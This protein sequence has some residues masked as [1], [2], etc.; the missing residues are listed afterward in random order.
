MGSLLNEGEIMT[1]R[2]LGCLLLFCT[3]GPL[4]A[5]SHGHGH[6]HVRM[7][8][9][10]LDTACAI[11]TGDTAQSI[12]FGTLAVSDLL[13]NGRSVSVPFTI[14]LVNCVLNGSDVR[15]RDHWKDV[16]I[17]FDGEPD[18]SHHFALKGTGRGEALAIADEAGKEAIPGEPMA[19]TTL[20][21]GSMALHYRMW[22][23]AGHHGLQP[24]DFRTTV[25]YFME[26]D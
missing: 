21:S 24:G 16:R 22:L 17:T 25:R 6:G 3:S 15:G 2:I 12:N 1:L 14:H 18:G 10:I 20:V 23:T 19:A 9:E 4:L 8:G 26:Y 11:D 13:N 7:S 5:A